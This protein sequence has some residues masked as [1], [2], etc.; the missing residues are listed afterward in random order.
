MSMKRWS[1]AVASALLTCGMAGAAQTQTP[2]TPATTDQKAG[3]SPAITLTGCV[4]KESAV[5]KRTPL[6]GDI[7]MSDEFVLTHSSVTPP[8]GS[9]ETPKPDAQAPPE[10]VGTAGSAVNFGRVYR[11][12]GDMEKDLKPYLGQRVSIVGRVKGKEK[13]TDD[14]SSIGT[15][16]KAAAGAWTPENTPEVTIESIAPATGSCAPAV[17]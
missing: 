10:P 5:L 15:S 11:L 6:A 14:L 17:K 1:T 2:S 3:A 13:I 16:G 4:Q 12:T 9:N 7:G 8:P